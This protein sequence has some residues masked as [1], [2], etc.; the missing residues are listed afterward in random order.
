MMAGVFAAFTVEAYLNH[1][2]PK[3][4][5]DWI[6][7]ERTTTPM[8][9]L[10]LLKNLPR[11]SIDLSKRPFGTLRSMLQLRNA[12]AHGKTETVRRERQGT[13]QPKRT[14]LHPEPDWMTLCTLAKSKRFV[15]DAE[16]MVLELQLQTGS[17]RNPFALL[18]SSWSRVQEVAQC[19]IQGDFGG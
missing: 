9:K 6:K 11:F 3:Y 7:V 14:E 10:L 1:I 18:G 15:E 16:R 13:K 19:P 2:S 12:L 4:V 8:E 5:A 17:S